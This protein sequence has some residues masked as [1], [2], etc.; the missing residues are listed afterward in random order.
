MFKAFMQQTQ[1]VAPQA[2]ESRPTRQAESLAVVPRVIQPQRRDEAPS[3]VSYV[4][5]QS[6]AAS[7][8]EGRVESAF[9]E[10]TPSASAAA[11]SE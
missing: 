11:E 1:Q 4:P 10:Q 3:L 2:T 7:S 5:E 6:V 9:S 8:G